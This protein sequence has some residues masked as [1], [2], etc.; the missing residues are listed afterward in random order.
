MIRRFW[1][2]LHDWFWPAP[3]RE[4]PLG[5]I[6]RARRMERYL[7]EIEG[8][9]Q[10]GMRFTYTAESRGPDGLPRRFTR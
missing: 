9:V 2:R 4:P 7:Q 8:E 1:Q 6:A 10:N 3:Y 5:P